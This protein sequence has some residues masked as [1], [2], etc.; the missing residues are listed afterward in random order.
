[1]KI[2]ISP[3]TFRKIGNIQITLCYFSIPSA[4]EAYGLVAMLLEEVFN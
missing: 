4:L 3:S 1:M 2:I